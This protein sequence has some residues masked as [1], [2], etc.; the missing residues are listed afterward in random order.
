MR[1]ADFIIALKEQ[2]ID[3]EVQDGNLK[4]SVPKGSEVLTPALKQQIRDQKAAIIEFFSK[5]TASRFTLDIPR[6]APQPD[7]AMSRSQKRFWALNQLGESA[8]VY[9]MCRS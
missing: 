2:Q 5:T 8:L 1:I 3:L 4:I 6:V 7:Y 9:N